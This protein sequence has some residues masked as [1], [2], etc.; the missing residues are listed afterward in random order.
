MVSHVEQFVRRV[1]L[2]QFAQF[3]IVFEALN[4]GS[5]IRLRNLSEHRISTTPL[6]RE[7]V[8]ENR[9]PGAEPNPEPRATTRALRSVPV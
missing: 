2:L 6:Q 3:R 7:R 4:A 9:Q 8:F 1:L 5:W